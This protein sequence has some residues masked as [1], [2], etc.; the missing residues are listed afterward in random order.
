MRPTNFCHPNELACIRTSRVPGKLCGF[1]RALAPWSLGLHAADQ[2]T[3]CFHDTRERF[4]GLQLDT[5]CLC[6]L[7][8][9][10]KRGLERGNFSSHG[11]HCNRASDTSVASSSF[12]KIAEHL[13]A[14]TGLVRFRARGLLREEAAKV[15]V[16]T[17]S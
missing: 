17:A 2:G 5:R 13:R 12:R 6:L 3:G 11:A 7:S 4:G 16:T 9:L 1:H 10:S 8:V 14:P 15:A